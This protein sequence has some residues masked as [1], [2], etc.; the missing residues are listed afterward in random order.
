MYRDEFHS[1]IGHVREQDL[2]LCI[3]WVVPCVTVSL[4]I[5]AKPV[6]IPVPKP[7][8]PENNIIKC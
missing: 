7:L 2:V 3:M 8:V 6:T 1:Q 4:A 5:S